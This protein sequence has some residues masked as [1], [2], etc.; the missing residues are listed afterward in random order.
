MAEKRI[1]IELQPDIAI[2]QVWSGLAQTYFWAG[3]PEQAFRYYSDALSVL[4]RDELLGNA[5]VND[6]LHKL[7]Y[8]VKLNEL[9]PEPAQTAVF[10][11]EVEYFIKKRHNLGIKKRSHLAWLANKFGYRDVSA[12][13]IN[14]VSAV[15]PVY[16]RSPELQSL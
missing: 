3:K 13:L 5:N 1:A 14:D 8:K 15:C 10:D 4:E 6:Q 9:S 12:S 16:S 7:Y 2:H 11:S